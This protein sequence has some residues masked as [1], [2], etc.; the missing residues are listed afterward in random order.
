MSEWVYPVKKYKLG[1]KFGVIDEK[2]PNGHRGDDLNGFKES[3]PLLAVHD[4]VIALSKLSKILGNVV[5]LRVDK[6]PWGKKF[7][8]IFFGYCHMVKPTH[9]K[10]GTQVKAGDVIGY[11]GNT[12]YSF[13][14][15]LHITL[16]LTLEGVFNGKVW[17]A[18]AYIGR[19]I[20]QATAKASAP[21]VEKLK[22]CEACTCTEG[23]K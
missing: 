8:S 4:G 21:V 6:A 13:G 9:L 20:A 2:H 15:H 5:V 1:P 14:V 10:V 22:C 3:T 7:L 18:M 23:C 12:G 16:A 11:A 17:S 19:R